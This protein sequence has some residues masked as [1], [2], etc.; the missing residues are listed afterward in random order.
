[1]SLNSL[2]SELLEQILLLT[3]A[4][5]TEGGFEGAAISC[6]GCYQVAKPLLTRYK[7]VLK[8]KHVCINAADPSST[9]ALLWDL[10]GDPTVGKHVEILDLDADDEDDEDSFPAE[11][12]N[13]QLRT[14]ID[15]ARF[16]SPESVD[17][18]TQEL[19]LDIDDETRIDWGDDMDWLIWRTVLLLIMFPNIRELALPA[20]WHLPRR[21]TD[22]H[23]PSECE[24]ALINMA[25]SSWHYTSPKPLAK[26][27]RLL[28]FGQP[29][30]DCIPPIGFD[31]VENFMILPTLTEMHVVNL[32]AIDQ[33]GENMPFEWSWVQEHS[34]LRDIHLQAC[35]MDAAGMR[36]L[37][38]VTPYLQKLRYS[39]M[40]KRDGV[41]HFWDLGAFVD[42]IREQRGQSLL[43]LSVTSS[44]YP[45]SSADFESY[46]VDLKGFSVL[47]SLVIDVDMLVDL[48]SS[49]LPDVVPL[50]EILPSTLKKL[51]LRCGV[52]D[53]RFLKAAC[54]LFGDADVLR[55]KSRFPHLEQITF[56]YEAA[57]GDH[58]QTWERM[59]E[60]TLPLKKA[61]EAVGAKL[62]FPGHHRRLAMAN[63]V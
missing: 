55:D 24:W 32:Y 52:D 27:E 26:L 63:R 39:H 4:E 35:C 15:E 28:P 8:Y 58:E 45:A 41:G 60:H 48:S 40:T 13:E 62:T 22:M 61:L 49:E 23:T 17:Q 12:R 37:L 44:G 51:K 9:L 43:E 31:V 50:S 18:W 34:F 21:S 42:A 2:P 38:A 53:S 59:Q 16:L 33:D 11:E 30:Y 14:M 57:Q 29:E 25:N 46:V 47:E 56:K 3:I 19:R 10:A 1:M 54:R 36:G 20:S 7:R 5:G 6:K